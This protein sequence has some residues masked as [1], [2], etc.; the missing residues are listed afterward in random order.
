[1]SRT[2]ISGFIRSTY[3]V[4]DCHRV[5]GLTLYSILAPFDAFEIS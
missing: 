2:D 5:S 3:L 1:M 4:P